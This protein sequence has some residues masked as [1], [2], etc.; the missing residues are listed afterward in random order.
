M[1]VTLYIIAPYTT[2]T[3]SQ[4]I[5]VSDQ[6]IFVIEISYIRWKTFK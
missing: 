3:D 4:P 5:L 1:V 2:I 6:I